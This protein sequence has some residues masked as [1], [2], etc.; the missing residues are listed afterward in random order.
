MMFASFIQ[1]IHKGQVLF[2][3]L[4]SLQRIESMFG[5]WIRLFHQIQ[6]LVQV[7]E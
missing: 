4:S 6:F 3:D 2:P 1:V 7:Q 5:E